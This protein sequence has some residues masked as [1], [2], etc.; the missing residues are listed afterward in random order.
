MAGMQSGG[1]PRVKPGLH[2]V[3]VVR[4]DPGDLATEGIART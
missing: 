4:D 1:S 2:F 3:V